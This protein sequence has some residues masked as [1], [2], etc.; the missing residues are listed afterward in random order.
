MNGGEGD[1]PGFCGAGDCALKRTENSRISPEFRS[2]ALQKGKSWPFPQ[3][4]QSSVALNGIQ[5]NTIN[6]RTSEIFS[7]IKKWGHRQ[8]VSKIKTFRTL[9]KDFQQFDKFSSKKQ[10]WTSVKTVNFEVLVPAPLPSLSPPL[11]YPENRL[12]TTMEKTNSLATTE[13][14]GAGMELPRSPAP[15]EPLCWPVRQLPE[16]LRS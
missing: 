12:L 14:G 15:R 10:R 9:L 4:T 8:N 13:G 6:P 5:W 1:W 7:S 16:R 2:W 3:N 11:W